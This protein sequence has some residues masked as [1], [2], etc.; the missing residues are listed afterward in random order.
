MY[1]LEF[2]LVVV[3]NLRFFIICIKMYIYKWKDDIMIL[4]KIIIFKDFIFR[5]LL[6]VVIG[7]VVG[8]VFNVIFGEI[9]KYFMDYYL[10]F[11]MLLGVVVVI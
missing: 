1:I 10:I 7:I 4:I 8:L 9:F 3:Y 6:G 5:V 2:K 11:K